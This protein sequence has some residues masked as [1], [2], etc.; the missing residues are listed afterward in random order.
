MAQR[1][2]AFA[3][4]GGFVVALAGCV[5]LVAS[6]VV[7]VRR[8]GHDARVLDL[9]PLLFL[10]ALLALRVGVLMSERYSCSACGER[11]RL[12]CVRCAGCDE[13]FASRVDGERPTDADADTPRHAM[14]PRVTNP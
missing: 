8:A 11:V 14:H 9:A 7:F 1:R 3:F 2:R 5:L 4:G 12:A 10:G 6:F 13:P